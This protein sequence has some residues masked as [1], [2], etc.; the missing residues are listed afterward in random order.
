MHQSLI[1][2]SPATA[3]SS[4][5]RSASHP[6]PSSNP[7]TGSSSSAGRTRQRRAPFSLMPS[8]TSIDPATPST[9]V[10][11]SI[12]EAALDVARAAERASQRRLS[13]PGQRMRQASAVTAGDPSARRM[14]ESWHSE[15]SA[16]SSIA[17]EEQKWM[18]QSA[19]ALLDK[20]G[21]SRHRDVFPVPTPQYEEAGNIHGSLDDG[22]Q[23]RMMQAV[24]SS[25]PTL[26][27]VRG[28]GGRGKGRR[29]AGMAFMSLGLL[30]GWD[31]P[32]T[33]ST[34]EGMVLP[35]EAESP[36]WASRPWPIRHPPPLIQ[37]SS[38]P[39]TYITFT[40]QSPLPDLPEKPPSFSRV[41]GRISA[42]SCTTLYLTSR[43]PQIWKNVCPISCM[44]C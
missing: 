13:R 43:L 7:A 42:W 39:S 32:S 41:V 38:P 21:R 44:I 4:R 20:R 3:T 6:A 12:Y 27:L 11:G 33:R 5:A 22:G 16:I 40:D 36:T 2:P 25:S 37:A 19:G 17:A 31:G 23:R 28:S 24:R 26:S 35:Q 29:A 9:P 14:A 34:L 18:S 8:T 15:L 10:V 1:L 30:V